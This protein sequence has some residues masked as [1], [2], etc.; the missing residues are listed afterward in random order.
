MP[1][2]S[3]ETIRYSNVCYKMPAFIPVLFYCFEA[4]NAGSNKPVCLTGMAREKGKG[5]IGETWFNVSS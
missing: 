1:E 3:L 5:N 2:F 4:Q